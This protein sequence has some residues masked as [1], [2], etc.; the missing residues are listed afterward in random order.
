MEIF[1]DGFGSKKNVW[2]EDREFPDKEK[3]E[4]GEER[5][6][7]E[8]EAG[9]RI[10]WMGIYKQRKTDGPRRQTGEKRFL[11]ALARNLWTFGVDRKSEKKRGKRRQTTGRTYWERPKLTYKVRAKGL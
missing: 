6:L 1:I 3:K 7:R 10:G 11:K 5:T 9:F 8:F 4:L 2:E